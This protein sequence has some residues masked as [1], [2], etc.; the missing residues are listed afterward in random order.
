MRFMAP[1][2]SQ[3]TIGLTVSLVVVQA[4]IVPAMADTTPSRESVVAALRHRER[5]VRAG[6]CMIIVKEKPTSADAIPKINAICKARKEKSGPLHYIISEEA[7][8]RSNKTI[9]WTGDGSMERYET[10]K[11][12]E[13]AQ[14]GGDV[15]PAVTAFDG[16][17]VRSLSHGKETVTGGI[18]SRESS[19]WDA[20][21]RLGGYSLIYK[22]HTSYL[23]D[24]MEASNHVDIASATLDSTPVLKVVFVH[25]K[26]TYQSFELTFDERMRLLRYST[27]LQMAGTDTEPRLY[28]A[29]DFED[30][31]AYKDTNGEVIDFPQ[32][33]TYHYYVGLDP[34][35]N[36]PVEYWS[37][38]ITIKNVA[39]NSPMPKELFTVD[40][41][42]E[43]KIHDGLTGRG[44]IGGPPPPEILDASS[45]GKPALLTWFIGGNVAFLAILSF[46]L[47]SRKR[48]SKRAM[49]H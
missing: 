9:I 28:E 34:A 19:H 11:T 5:L 41:P 8:S 2:Q 3:Y 43:A 17:V 39:F 49:E 24:L 33:A 16:Q 40:F 44:W 6:R 26:F 47:L 46:L 30:Y 35:T 36:T 21:P 23:S 42:E 48:F 18:D 1:R 45:G 13:E 29:H 27:T 32:K 7:A 12:P 31:K 4:G 10:Y 38:A 25:P 20:A 22:Y 37:Q 14:K 15:A